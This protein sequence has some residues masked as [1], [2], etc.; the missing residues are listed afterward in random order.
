MD[1]QNLIRWHAQWIGC[2]SWAS[3]KLL[4]YPIENPTFFHYSQNYKLII[5]HHFPCRFTSILPNDQK[6][7]RVQR[8]VWQHFAQDLLRRRRPVLATRFTAMT[9]R[10]RGNLPV[11]LMDTSKHQPL[12]LG[13]PY[14][15]E[16]PRNRKWLF[17]PWLVSPRF[18]GYPIYIYMMA[19]I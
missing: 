18:V 2:F 10:N 13:V 19:Y 7:P 14:L 15:E 3:H 11:F 1:L 4:Y 5:A 17:W 12:E 8:K 16:H 6:V 9:C